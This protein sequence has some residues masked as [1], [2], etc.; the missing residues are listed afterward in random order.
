[1][2]IYVYDNC[3]INIYYC[4][5]KYA[6]IVFVLVCNT[7]VTCMIYIIYDNI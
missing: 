3:I 4:V 2:F 5:Q 7:A 1:M 6:M